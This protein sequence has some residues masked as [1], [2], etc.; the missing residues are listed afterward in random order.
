VAGEEVANVGL[1]ACYRPL[2]APALEHD[3]E[4]PTAGPAVLAAS[5]QEHLDAAL[6]RTPVPPHK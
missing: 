6:T 1:H 2:V 5:P 3:R 4:D